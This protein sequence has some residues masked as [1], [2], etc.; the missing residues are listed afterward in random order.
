MAAAISGGVGPAR[1]VPPGLGGAGGGGG[2]TVLAGDGAAYVT[3]QTIHVNGG[4]YMR[5][6]WLEGDA[7]SAV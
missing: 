6:G 7:A 5:N 1:Q 4:L 3:G 2:G